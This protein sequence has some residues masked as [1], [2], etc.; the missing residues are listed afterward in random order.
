MT[1]SRT[2]IRIRIRQ[3]L[4]SLQVWFPATRIC[5]A[6]SGTDVYPHMPILRPHAARFHERRI[7]S[8][9]FTSAHLYGNVYMRLDVARARADWSNFWLLAK[10]TKWEIPCLGRRC[11]VVQNVTP[12]ALSSAEKSVAVQTNKQT[13]KHTSKQ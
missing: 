4:D 2:R 11:T 6:S 8:L 9:T 7:F 12:L 5:I 10:F 1:Q 3:M 13:N